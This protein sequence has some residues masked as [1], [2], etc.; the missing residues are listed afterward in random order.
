MAMKSQLRLAFL[1][2]CL[3]SIKGKQLESRRK[4]DA[5]LSWK[6]WALQAGPAGFFL[7][8]DGLIA[9]FLLK[10]RGKL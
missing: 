8:K 10:Y 2:G 5:T 9:R 6:N 7:K 4:A 3:S 1:L